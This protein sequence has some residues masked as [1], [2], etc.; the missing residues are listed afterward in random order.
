MRVQRCLWPWAAT[1]ALLLLAAPPLIAQIVPEPAEG[2]VVLLGDK[3][4]VY[5]L[6][7]FKVPEEK[8]RPGVKRP[9]VNL[10]LVLDRSGSMKAQGKMEYAKRAA[11]VVVA[12]AKMWL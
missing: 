3:R 11:K 10:A 9:P 5:V 8:L 7:E 1:V 2:D 4:P 12:A 6:V